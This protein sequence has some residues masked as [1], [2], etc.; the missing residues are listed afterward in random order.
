MPRY[1]FHIRTAGGQLNRDDER[2]E[3][4]DLDAAAREAAET[5]RCFAADVERGG[6]DYTGCYFEVRSESG[7]INVP[8][9]L[10]ETVPE[11]A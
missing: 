1:F 4:P 5:A 3:L 6:Y 10:I 9:F 2:V 11:P 7:S 8:A